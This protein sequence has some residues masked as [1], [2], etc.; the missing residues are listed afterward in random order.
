MRL[1]EGEYTTARLE[2]AG[3]R[4]NTIQS[5]KVNAGWTV[6]LYDGD[7]FSGKSVT[8]AAFVRE[9]NCAEFK[10]GRKTSSLKVIKAKTAPLLP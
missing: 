1:V 5:V 9:L 4:D 8:C 6:V 3:I 2:A 10:F 7:N